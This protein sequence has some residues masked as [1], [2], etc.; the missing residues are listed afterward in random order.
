MLIAGLTYPHEHESHAISI[1]TTA[2]LVASATALAGFL[3]A[4]VVYC[5]RLLNPAEVANQFGFIYRLLWN[6]WYFDEL[7]Q[8]VF[9]EPVMFLARR[10]SDFDLRVIDRFVNGCAAAVLRVSI[11]DDFID[12]WFVDGAVNL[13]A[14]WIHSAGLALRGVQTGRVRQYVM[15]V[16]VGTVGLFILISFFWNSAWGA[17]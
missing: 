5:W 16:V 17:H 15:F 14:R 13:T 12:R 9:V 8:A 10:A 7:Y 11:L 6:K 2:T 1:H 3:L 4:T